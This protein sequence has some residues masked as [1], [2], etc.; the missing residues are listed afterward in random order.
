MPMTYGGRLKI[1]VYSENRFIAET[2]FL[3]MEPEHNADLILSN[4]DELNNG[5]QLIDNQQFV[6]R[7]RSNEITKN[8]Q[9]KII[10]YAYGAQYFIYNTTIYNRTINRINLG[11][12][13]MNLSSLQNLTIQYNSI[14]SV[15]NQPADRV[16]FLTIAFEVVRSSSEILW[17]AI[18]LYTIR[19]FAIGDTAYTG[20]CPI[21]REFQPNPQIY[22]DKIPPCPCRVLTT[23][24]ENQL[25]YTVDKACDGR[26]P[27]NETCKFHQGAK[28]CYRRKSSTA[29]AGAHCCYDAQ[30]LWINDPNKGA[31]TLDAYSSDDSIFFHFFYDVLPYFSCCKSIISSSAEECKDYIHK[32]PPGRCENLLPVPSGGKC[33]P[34]FITLNGSSYT[35]NGYGE[36]TLVKSTIAQF[37]IQVRLVPVNVNLSNT[38]EE[39]ATA[40]V[41]FVI[42]NGNQSRVQFELFPLQKL[43]QILIDNRSVEYTPLTEE[44]F[45]FLSTSPI[46]YSDDRQF[47]IRQ[48]NV[49]SF[50]II[51][52]ES[53]MQF[54]VYVRPSFDFL[55]L[56]SIIPRD[57]MEKGKPQGLMGD[58][59]GLTFPNGTRMS[60]TTMND[61]QALFSYGESWR[62]TDATSLFYYYY[63][64][65]HATHQNFSYQPSFPQDIFKKYNG[66]D[67]FRMAQD[68]CRNM[69]NSQQ[70][71]YDVL[72][73]NDPTI[74]NMHKQF[75]ANMN[76]W[77]KYIEE[78]KQDIR[79]SMSSSSSKFDIVIGWIWLLMI[80]F[81]ITEQ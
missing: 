24:A 74:S 41:A 78:V 53:N 80:S 3:A 35:F 50:E 4:Y 45:K 34:H 59:D 51:Y 22:I 72:I 48:T 31:G 63:Q 47:R 29:N 52:G 16:Y 28:G 33:D 46:I 25:G 9:F 56:L 32:R 2:D 69:T 57:T 79:N 20:F 37:E 23:W 6:L 44:D 66:T 61:D 18:P 26:K 76:I 70:C 12:E 75:D 19:I 7:F 73:T 10:V 64:S 58:L 60:L 81:F 27:A 55:D 14:F 71:L 15:A 68:N 42:K 39:K 62:T 13:A 43:I 5:I 21:W 17:T 8:Y 40:I 77:E 30:G 36:Y 11:S 38:S 54:T 67:R 65:S 1:T 49:T